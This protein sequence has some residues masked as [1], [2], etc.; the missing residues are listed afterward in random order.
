MICGQDCSNRPRIKDPK[1]RYYCKSCHEQASRRQ[2][3]ADAAPPPDESELHPYVLAGLDEPPSS[4]AEPAGVAVTCPACG[5][6]LPEGT[7]VCVT[8]G[9]N[10]DTGRSIV[11]SRR[12]DQNRV[13][14]NTEGVL[15]LVSWFEPLGFAPVASEAMGG[16]RPYAVWAIALLTIVVSFWFWFSSGTQMH[17]R[18]ELMLW[19]GDATPSADVIMMLYEWTDWGDAQA[20]DARMRQLQ[21]EE[22]LGDVPVRDLDDLIVE[23]HQSLPPAQR[24]I[25]TFHPYQ[26]LT[27]ALLHGGIF[28]LAG[29]L[30]FLLIFGS[31]VSAL[32]GNTGVVI[33][34][35]ILAVIAALAEMAS[36]AHAQPIPML[37]ASGAIMG[38]AGMYFVLF[39]VNR[40]YIAAW[41]RFL[42]FFRM[43]IW[44]PRGFW[45]VLLYVAFDVAWVSFG[46]ENGVAHWAHLG[47]FI[48]GALFAV[49][50][51][52]SRV[53]NAAG[54]D[55]IT[56]VLGRHAW[57]LI[58]R[59]TG[60]QRPGLRI[61][62]P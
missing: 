13:Y 32:I 62:L 5:R 30:L 39:P 25:G 53:L 24:V 12:L 47:G 60:D 21:D 37:G 38:L 54:G 59:P 52:V 57:K 56:V 19:S 7:H 20:F 26:L 61:P 10:I 48:A 51:L 55:L 3:V 1:G 16:R 49:I 8:C 40:M 17:H 9:I 33:L 23:A 2:Q 50:L 41:F 58:G 22:A 42:F 31:R 35:P 29:N 46:A 15:R 28:H 34:Y 11:T 18:K 43:K 6:S 36:T 45:V 27:H 4:P 44:G 14:T